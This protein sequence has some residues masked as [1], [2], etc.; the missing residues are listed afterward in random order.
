MVADYRVLS[1]EWL[2]TV[3][4]LIVYLIT[5]G[6]FVFDNRCSAKHCDLD[7]VSMMSLLL[8]ACAYL[9]YSYKVASASMCRFQWR[10]HARNE[11]A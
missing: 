2:E 1:A 9:L 7:F 5:I 6:Y 3:Q 10:V 4:L 11:F 8:A